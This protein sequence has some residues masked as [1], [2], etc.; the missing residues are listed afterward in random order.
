MLGH[1]AAVEDRPDLSRDP[2]NAAQRPPGASDLRV[3]RG[4]VGF[5]GQQQILA[6]A[7]PLG[8]QGRIAADDQPLARVIGRGDRGHVALVEQRELQ[9]AA[10]DQAAD[11]RRSQGSDPIEP[12]RAQLGVDAGMGDHAAIA[13]QDDMAQGEALF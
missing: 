7:R 3:D 5:G 12:A 13:D 10:L 4:E 9:S 11:R 6:L 8:G 2:S 1:V